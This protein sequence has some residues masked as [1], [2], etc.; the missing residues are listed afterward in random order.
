MKT[1]NTKTP[2]PPGLENGDLENE[3]PLENEDL[4]EVVKSCQGVTKAK[5]LKNEDAGPKTPI[6]TVGEINTNK[7]F[8]G[9]TRIVTP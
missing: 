1:S 8:N 9:I 4:M 5:I 6:K 2:P 3:D 7:T